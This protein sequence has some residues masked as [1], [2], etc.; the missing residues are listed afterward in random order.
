[1]AEQKKGKFR[2]GAC[3]TFAR[4]SSHCWQ[5]KQTIT[6]AGGIGGAWVGGENGRWEEIL[7]LKRTRLVELQGK[8]EWIEKRRKDWRVRSTGDQ[9][10]DMWP[11]TT[12]L[13]WEWWY[14][15][16]LALQFNFLTPQ[17]QRGNMDYFFILSCWIYSQQ[18]DRWPMLITHQI[19]AWN[20][21][22]RLNA[23]FCDFTPEP[24]HI[25]FIIIQS[26]LM[27]FS[28]SPIQKLQLEAI[29]EN[30]IPV[31]VNMSDAW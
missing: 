28:V 17:R 10:H 25:P 5:R 15:L 1:M 6:E 21:Q 9:N 20:L 11:F 26:H 8:A 29:T 13:S 31:S 14:T 23:I 18:M 30:S 27:H 19:S 4:I 2:I 12:S 22:S 24:S 7:E 3:V 16:L